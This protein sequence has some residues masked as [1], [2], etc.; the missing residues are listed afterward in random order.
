MQPGNPL[1]AT[2]STPQH[3]YAEIDDPDK[4]ESRAYGGSQTVNL[5]NAANATQARTA[6]DQVG[7]S[8]P[9]DMHPNGLV[10]DESTGNFRPKD[11]SGSVGAEPHD[12]RTR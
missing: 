6:Q 9:A 3:P 5:P 1:G 12:R 2:N 11:T 4:S 8:A 10:F 7:E